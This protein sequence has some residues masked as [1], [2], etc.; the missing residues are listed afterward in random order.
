LN[1]LNVL[2]TGG[3]RGIGRG[4][5]S[6]FVRKGCNVAFTYLSS[7]KAAFDLVETLKKED[8]LAKPYKC[9]VRDMMESKETVKQVIEEF[10]KLDVLVNNAGIT[11]DS[12]L[13]MMSDSKWKEV[14]DTNLNSLYNITKPVATH[15]LRNKNGKIINISSVAGIVGINGQTNYCSTKAGIIGFTKSLAVELAPYNINVNGIA[16]GYINTDMLDQM[17]ER[18]KAEAFNRIP[19]GYLGEVE[20]VANLAGFLCSDQSR[21]ITGQVIT[22]DGGL[23]TKLL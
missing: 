17:D 10:G 9:D 12:S 7:S 22:I 15:F 3:S 2:I 1:R 11:R 21:Y 23:T 18:K 4:L 19:L 14:I 20:D 6:Y 8:G 13:L 16:P 5:V